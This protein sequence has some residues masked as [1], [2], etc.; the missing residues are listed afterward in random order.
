MRI[1]LNAGKFEQR[2]NDYLPQFQ[3]KVKNALVQTGFLV[4]DEAEKKA[5]IDEGTLI[6]SGFVQVGKSTVFQKE[7]TKPSSSGIKDTELRVGYTVD[8]AAKLHE[9][10]FNPGA[11]SIEKGL[12]HPGYKWLRNA[13]KS[14]DIKKK[15]K[16]YL[17]DELKRK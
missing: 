14:F 7:G 11:K 3:Q 9:N 6:G 1:K 17:N 12:T 4:L 10:P 5:P 8:Y 13:A 15:F 2:L 16:E